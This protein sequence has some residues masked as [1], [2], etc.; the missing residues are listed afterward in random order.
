LLA[1]KKVTDTQQPG[2][3]IK[4]RSVERA[5]LRSAQIKA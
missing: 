1:M 5:C 3:M 4:L 2:R